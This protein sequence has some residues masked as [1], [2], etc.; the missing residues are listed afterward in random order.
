MATTED[1]I[2]GIKAEATL[3]DAWLRF[4]PVDDPADSHYQ[5]RGN[6]D[7][8]LLLASAALVALDSESRQADTGNLFP[9]VSPDDQFVLRIVYDPLDRRSVV[10]RDWKAARA[11]RLLSRVVAGIVGALALLSIVGLVTV[12]RWLF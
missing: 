5:L 12:L 2:A 8:L 3:E 7:G 1:C 9:S 6:R 4:E 11:G 10:D